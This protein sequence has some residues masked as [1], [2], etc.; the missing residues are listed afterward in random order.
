LDS[1]NVPPFS[2]WCGTIPPSVDTFN[3]WVH[4]TFKDLP[5]DKRPAWGLKVCSCHL[6][7]VAPPRGPPDLLATVFFFFLF[8]FFRNFFFFDIVTPL[9]LC[10]IC[11]VFLQRKSGLPYCT[12]M[13]FSYVGARLD[14]V[15]EPPSAFSPLS[16]FFGFSYPTF[17]FS[18][19]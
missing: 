9:P 8:G 13:L 11:A 12:C 14:R 7:K 15:P 1:T 10:S 5:A 2:H 6:I 16:P 19:V 18:F 17:I 3:L 4:T